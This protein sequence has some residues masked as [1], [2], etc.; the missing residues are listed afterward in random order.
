MQGGDRM[1][2][3]EVAIVTG[4][5]SGI[6]RAACRRVAEQG[7]AVAVLDVDAAAAQ[8]VAEEIG[9]RAYPVDVTDYDTFATAVDAATADL[10]APAFCSTTPAGAASAD[11]ATRTSS[12]GSS[13]SPST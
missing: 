9:G 13:S 8:L 10:G 2:A 6:G 4:G 12:S 11:W 7:A 3:G 5:G 1:L